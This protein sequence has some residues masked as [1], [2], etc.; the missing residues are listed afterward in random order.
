MTNRRS[1]LQLLGVAPIAGKKVAEETVARLSGVAMA[2]SGRTMSGGKSAQAWPA[3]N[4]PQ[5]FDSQAAFKRAIGSTLFRD[6][7]TSLLYDQHRQVNAIDP[8]I[9]VYRSFSLNAKIAFQRQRNVARQIPTL[10]GEASPF[11][12][13]HLLLRKVTNPFG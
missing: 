7:L 12:R 9:A 6:E 4:P 11:S 1:F 5:T 2:P 10:V 13:M 3:D 8:D